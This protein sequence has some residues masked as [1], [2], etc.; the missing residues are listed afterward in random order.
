MQRKRSRFFHCL[1][2]ST[3]AHR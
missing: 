2:C 1:S 3:M